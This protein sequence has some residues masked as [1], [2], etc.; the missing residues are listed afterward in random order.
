MSGFSLRRRVLLA[1]LLVAAAGATSLWVYLRRFEQELSG[2]PRIPV[3]VALELLERGTA[4][5]EEQLAVREIPQSYV[6]ERFVRAVDR[7]RVLGLRLANSLRPQQTLLWTDLAVSAHEQRHLSALI[8][9]GNRAMSVRFGGPEPGLSLIRPG[10]YADIIADLPA[11]DRAVRAAVVL[12]QRVLVL[13]VG[14]RT[15]ARAAPSETNAYEQASLT[16]SVTLRQAQLLSLAAEQG[17]LSVVLRN[18]D[19]PRTSSDVADVTSAALHDSAARAVG[20]RAASGPVRLE[21]TP[22]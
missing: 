20:Q 3:L 9:V 2:G 13:A 5:T 8:P 18:P 15:E 21:S 6:E 11:P 4:L 7:P 14:A 22:P 1:A 17:R 16:L 12:L 10:D 19:D